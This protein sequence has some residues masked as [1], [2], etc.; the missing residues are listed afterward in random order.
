MRVGVVLVVVV[1]FVIVVL[2][3]L[4]LLLFLFA[5]VRADLSLPANVGENNI[6]D[7]VDKNQR[8][9]FFH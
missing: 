9:N 6:V 3:L 7:Q 5:V 4:F 2:L 1:V 8:P